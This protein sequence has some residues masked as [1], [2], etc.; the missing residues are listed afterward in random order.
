MRHEYDQRDSYDE[1]EDGGLD[2]VDLVFAILRRWQII[3][4]IAIPVVIAGAFYASTRPTLYRADVTMMITNP[5]AAAT[6]G[7]TDIYV[8]EKLTLTYTQLVKSKDIMAR[9]ISKYDLADSPGGLASRVHVNSVE[10]TAFMKL[11]YTSGEA[12][13]T[14]PVINEIANEFIYKIAEVVK[15]RNITILERAPGAYQL[16]KKRGTIVVAAIILGLALG[17]GVAGIIELIHK[18]LRKSSDIEKVLGVKMLGMIPEIDTNK[19]AKE[20]EEDNE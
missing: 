16:P 19:K 15:L 9:V 10:G 18:K 12:N 13:L 8:N 7:A 14:A 5:N 20:G 6:I 3:I 17:C 2:L 4:L 11:S 1:E